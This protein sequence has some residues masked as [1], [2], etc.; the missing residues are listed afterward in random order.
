VNSNKD[1]KVGKEGRRE[2][3][4]KISSFIPHPSSFL[5]VVVAVLLSAVVLRGAGY[6]P[7]VSW[8]VMI[9]GSVGGQYQIADTLTKATPLILC[10]LGVAVAFRGGQFNIGAEG[11]LVI[12]ALAA[13]WLGGLTAWGATG[14]PVVLGAAFIAGGAWGF[15]PALLKT[16]RDV[17]EVIST[18]MLNFV[19]ALTVGWL[20]HGPLQEASKGYPQTEAVSAGLALPRVWAPTRLHAGIAVAVVACVIAAVWLRYTAT[21]LRLRVAGDSPRAARTA[22][23]DFRRMTWLT[24]FLSGGC[25]G[26]A[27]GVEVLGV[28]RRL[29]EQFSPGYGFMAIA[30]ALLARLNPVSVIPAAVFFGAL[31][32][33]VA[34]LQRMAGVSAGFAGVVEASVILTVVAGNAL[35]RSGISRA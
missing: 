17:S 19:A 21:G 13:A 11:Q 12:G 7:I 30:V 10:G 15:I 33:G 4:Y 9:A 3:K 5:P 28:S 24:L 25:A 34:A 1:E 35:F 14:I 31:E 29:Y 27:G 20:V 2:M 8:Q 32:T 6:D 26:L 18:L 16:E 22:G 23:V